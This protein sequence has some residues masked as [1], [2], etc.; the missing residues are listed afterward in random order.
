[1]ITN[2]NKKVICVKDIPSNIIEE[3]IFILKNDIS[4]EKNEKRK[5][6]RKEIAT[7]E[8]EDFLKDYIYQMEKE[9][10]KEKEENNLV[11]KIMKIALIAV[12]GVLACYLF[13]SAVI[14]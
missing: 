13:I 11:R 10:M 5:T 4:F 9:E 2:V 7:N 6:N 14:N 3:A 12:G 8:A 1:M